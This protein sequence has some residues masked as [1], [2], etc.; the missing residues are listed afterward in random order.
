MLYVTRKFCPEGEK[1]TPVLV[2][3]GAL[4]KVGETSLPQRLPIERGTFSRTPS[5]NA[6][7]TR[8][9]PLGLSVV[10][11]AQAALEVKAHR[12]ACMCAGTRRP[13]LLVQ[14]VNSPTRS[15]DF[16]GMYHSNTNCERKIS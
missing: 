10:D 7:S 14:A 3:V 4:G 5:N 9:L 12:R 2:E 6:Q 11:L 13:L 15:V 16:V 1:V 8:Q